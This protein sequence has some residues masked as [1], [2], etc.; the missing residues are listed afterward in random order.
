MRAEHHQTHQ[1]IAIL[2]Q[3]KALAAMARSHYPLK[4]IPWRPRIAGIKE[5]L[6]VLP[7]GLIQGQLRNHG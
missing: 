5:V 6:K 1:G 7:G 4:H 2:G 3:P